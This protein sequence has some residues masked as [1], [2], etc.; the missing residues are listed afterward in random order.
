MDDH[1]KRNMIEVPFDVLKSLLDNADL[2]FAGTHNWCI[3]EA[4]A[5]LQA[6]L[7]IESIWSGSSLDMTGCHRRK[8]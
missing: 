1:D 4:V 6:L 3:F 5:E 2:C 7:G 8:H